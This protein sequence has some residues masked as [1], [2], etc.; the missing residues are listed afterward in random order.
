MPSLIPSMTTK[1]TASAGTVSFAE[2]STEGPLISREAD[3][4]LAQGRR[5]EQAEGE[6]EQ[7]ESQYALGVT[8][9]GLLGLDKER[10]RGLVGGRER[11]RAFGH[12]R[13]WG[14]ARRACGPAGRRRLRG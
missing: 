4:S 3:E 8:G 10:V 9:F 6:R 2:P 12:C 5:R 13:F 14:V 1:A 7:A 11:N